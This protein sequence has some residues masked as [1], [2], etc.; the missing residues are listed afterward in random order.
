MADD[1]ALDP[2]SP[3]LLGQEVSIAPD[4][5]EIAIDFRVRIALLL[6]MVPGGAVA[7][8]GLMQSSLGVVALGFI[9]FI[10]SARVVT[11]TPWTGPSSVVVTSDGLALGGRTIPAGEILRVETFAQAAGAGS[12]FSGGLR[13]RS[14]GMPRWSIVVARAGAPHETI[15]LGGHG[16]WASTEP[17]DALVAAMNRV[18]GVRDQAAR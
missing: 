7:W 10:L 13:I 2:R 14:P 15:P 18:L 4:R 6:G 12:V 16:V 8:W 9:P 5:V 11:R 3:W 1:R 17:L